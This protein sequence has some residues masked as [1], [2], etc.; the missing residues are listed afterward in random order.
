MRILT[1]GLPLLLMVGCGQKIEYVEVR[2]DVPGELLTPC[3][4]SGRQVETVKELA[5]LATEH[6]R[7]AKCANSKITSLAEIINPA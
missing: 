6:R 1:L 2:P 4:I 7:S 3:P 5:V